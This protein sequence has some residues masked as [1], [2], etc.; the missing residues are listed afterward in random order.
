M[1]EI[2]NKK[3]NPYNN[4]EAHI[5]LQRMMANEERL[6]VTF[7]FDE[8]GY[9]ASEIESRRVEK[10]KYQL[11]Y[12]SLVFIIDYL[13]EKEIPYGGIYPN[14][15]MPVEEGDDPIN[16]QMLIVLIN[17]GIIPHIR[18]SFI[19]EPGKLTATFKGK[20]G[21]I[22]LKMDRNQTVK[23]ILSKHNLIS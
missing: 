9:Y 21:T 6:T 2:Q 12:D 4:L 18:P 7:A 20:K 11:S 10:F 19:D 8:Y 22:I 17:F 1:E 3:E 16:E 23:E 13:F 5:L 15:P 14:E